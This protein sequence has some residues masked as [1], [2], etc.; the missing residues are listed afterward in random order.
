MRVKLVTTGQHACPYLPDRTSSNRAFWA[1]EIPP[2]VYQAFMDAGF[3]RSGKVVYQPTCRGCRRCISLRVPVA[4]FQPS[5]SQ[6][7]TWRKNQDLVVTVGP[8][9]PD[10]E[11]FRLYRKY[12]TEWHGKSAADGDDDAS[13]ES[14]VSFLYDSPVDTLEWQYRDGAGRLIGVGLCDRSDASLSSVYFYHDPADARRGIGTFG[15]LYEIEECR[16]L[17]AAHY[18][19][20]YWVD[21]C[22]AMSYKA[23]YRPHEILLPD[24]VWRPAAEPAAGGE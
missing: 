22:P 4:T 9:E 1:E 5:K 10:E 16:R 6:R 13:Y 3:R 12:V 20:G 2:P 15:A 19:L 14:F 21:G 18:Y 24:G 17:G 11:R 7:R 8:A 23:T